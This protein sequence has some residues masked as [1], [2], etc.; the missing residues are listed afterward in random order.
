MFF[1]IKYSDLADGL[2]LCKGV[3]EFFEMVERLF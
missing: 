1:V 3:A 2:V